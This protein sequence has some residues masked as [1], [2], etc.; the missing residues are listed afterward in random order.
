MIF[1]IHSLEIALILLVILF[2][3]RVIKQYHGENIAS[4]N[5]Q[6]NIDSRTISTVDDSKESEVGRSIVE[7]Y[8]NDFFP[9]EPDL[10]T[11]SLSRLQ[12][13]HKEST[14][15]TSNDLAVTPKAETNDRSISNKVIEAMMAEADLACAS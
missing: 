3:Y 6:H 7:A 9:V 13:A 14:N 2:G 1:L 15:T 4:P 8:I 11:S 10:V 5:I 12:T